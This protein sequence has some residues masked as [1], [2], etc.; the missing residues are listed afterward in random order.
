ME[1]TRKRHFLKSFKHEKGGGAEREILWSLREHHALRGW[2]ERVHASRV[3]AESVRRECMLR[4]CV[5]RVR[6]EGARVEK[7]C[8]SV[9]AKIVDRKI[10]YD[11]V[12]VKE[13][14]ERPQ[15]P[16]V[17]VSIS[18]GPAF[19]ALQQ[20]PFGLHYCPPA[21]LSCIKSR[22]TGIGLLSCT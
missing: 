4:G 12:S 17:W 20:I 15:R 9:C 18:I 11:S 10:Y 6:Q 8:V 7:E 22:P 5:E 14:R 19:S 21:S 3:C 2:A 13:P 16:W 1:Q